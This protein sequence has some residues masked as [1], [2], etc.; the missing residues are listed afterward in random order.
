LFEAFLI[1]NDMINQSIVTSCFE[2][3]FGYEQTTNSDY[4][5]LATNILT[6]VGGRNIQ[7]LHPLLTTENLH[8]CAPKNANFS[9]YLRKKRINSIE[10]LIDNIYTA[11]QLN[12]NSKE[13]LSEVRLYEGSGNF[14]NKIIKQNRFVGFKIDMIQSDLSLMIKSIG[15]QLTEL[16]PNFKLY[17]Y[18]TSKL[19]PIGTID[20]IH[21]KAVSFSW[22]T[23]ATQILPEIKGSYYIGYYESD[24]IG[25]AIYRDNNLTVSPA[26]NSCS[27][28]NYNL[29]QSWSKF[30]NLQSFYV[31][32]DNLNNDK[33]KWTTE[34]E[35]YI[36]NTNF[37]LNLQISVICDLSGLFCRN[38]ELFRDALGKQL[39]VDFLNEIAYSNRDNQLR[40]KL[41]QMAFIALGDETNGVKKELEKAVK[42]INYGT[43]DIN[44]LCLPCQNN[45]LKI[46]YKS[47][48]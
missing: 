34:S 16:N 24:L 2:N 44:Q 11:K 35:V 19:E 43:S 13:L 17:V 18:H 41:V 5:T 6:G 21:N 37:G 29:F 40:E 28:V 33:T 12:E 20:I 25:Q 3:L 10:K 1:K 31:D 22:F 7:Q 23:I 27:P 46:K 9:D 48:D 36:N 30:V 38:K 26:C 47:R 45:A 15:L 39:T 8:N 4:P 14:L 32:I 42:A